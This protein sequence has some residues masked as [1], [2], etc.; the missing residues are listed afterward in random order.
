MKYCVTLTPNSLPVTRWPT[1]CSPMETASPTANSSTP[2]V[3]SSTVMACH[4]SR[5][6]LRPQPARLL[7]GPGVGCQH[8][9]DGQ[10]PTAQGYVVG[11]QHALNRRHDVGEPQ[12]AGHERVHADLVGGVVDRRGGAAA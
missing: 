11:V 6:R 5:S 2:S 3:Y 12:L 8:I 7:A 10:L 4:P 1:S 9:V